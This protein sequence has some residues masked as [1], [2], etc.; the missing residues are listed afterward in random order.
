M[1]FKVGDVLFFVLHGR[2]RGGEG[3]YIG[4]LKADRGAVVLRRSQA[5]CRDGRRALQSN[6]TRLSG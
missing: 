2:W 5:S 6:K 3:V 1:N 4:N